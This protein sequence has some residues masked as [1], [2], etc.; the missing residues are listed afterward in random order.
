[1]NHTWTASDTQR[2]VVTAVQWARMSLIG[3]DKQDK[4]VDG[5]SPGGQ[6]E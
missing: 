6:F 5:H 3:N 2:G 1:M 4:V